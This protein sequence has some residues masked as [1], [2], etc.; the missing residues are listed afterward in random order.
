MQNENRRSLSSRHLTGSLSFLLP[1]FL[2]AIAFA[3]IGIHPIGNKSILLVD[4]KLQYVAFFSE[5]MRQLRFFELPLFS[6]FFGS[7]MNFY[8]TWAY[9][10]AS[11]VNLLL[12]LFPKAYI[13]D[14][15]FVVLLVKTGLC[16]TTFYLYARKILASE[17]WRALLFSTSYALC[18]FLVSYSDNMQWL[19][20]VIW[21]PIVIMG[22]EM[23]YRKGHCLY[24]SFAVA[25]LVISN[26]YISVLTG[27]FCFLYSTYVVLR[28]NKEDFPGRR[29]KF[30]LKIGWNSLLGVGMAAFV[31]LPI[32]FILRNQMNLIGQSAPPTLFTVNPFRTI[33]GLFVGRWDQFTEISFPKIYSGLLAVVIA[34]VYFLAGGI[35]RREKIVTVLFLA[36]VFVCFHV[37]VLNFIW[38]GLDYTGWFP[39]RY[40]FVFSFLILTA[41]VKAMNSPTTVF[42]K[43]RVF[44]TGYIIAAM[45]VCL[46]SFLFVYDS[47]GLPLLLIM[48]AAN[49]TL[50]FSYYYLLRKERRNLSVIL[51]LLCVELAMSTSFEIATLNSG[52]TYE[53][54]DTWTNSYRTVEATIEKN[55]LRGQPGRTAVAL[56]TITSND[57]LLFGLEG[58]DFYSSA[59]NTK[60]ADTL[61]RLGYQ[62]YISPGFEISDNGGSQ[63]LNSLMGVSS[64]IMETTELGNGGLPATV[65]PVR[66]L[67]RKDDLLE[68]TVIKNPLALSTAY[69]VSKDILS[70]SLSDQPK[71][72]LED[73]FALT[74]RLLSSML[75]NDK[76]TYEE[77]PYTLEYS[78]V[79]PVAVSTD[80]TRYEAQDLSEKSS[81]SINLLGKGEDMPLYLDMKYDVLGRQKNIANLS[82]TILYDQKE[83][84][85]KYPDE[86]VWAFVLSLGSFPEGQPVTVELN[87]TGQ[88]L[89]VWHLRLLSQDPQDVAE[90]LSPLYINQADMEWTSSNSMRIE[91]NA[92]ED[93]VLFVSIPYDAGW[94]AYVNGKPAEVLLIADAFM[95]IQ[96]E[97][98]ENVIEMSFFPDGLK[99]GIYISLACFAVA[100]FQ[101]IGSKKQKNS[102]I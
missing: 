28:E 9:Y 51:L 82:V 76:I 97:K 81:V 20:G 87:Y 34:P 38:H 90:A 86:T 73:P 61:Y 5:Y 79:Q 26:F 30:L 14:G 37:S 21:L 99:A 62:R 53:N 46:L 54:Y 32:F 64:T 72:L 6:R 100:L 18:G 57:P 31:L 68:L 83:Q 74:D 10:L 60:L 12:L 77:V 66:H 69:L 55:N 63:L 67:L 25:V 52:A 27:V 71:N 29:Q 92:E 7:G 80:C 94:R 39:F 33:G 43:N 75:N 11:P 96:L 19:D 101:I 65:F 56:E 44:F 58:I 102:F 1:V 47:M 88:D 48:A 49:C 42:S 84:Q 13:L 41:A 59:G 95:G 70:F 98:G 16:G 45:A 78:N 24:Y 2:M 8:G 3:M 35:K 4:G 85:I 15:M 36:F 93:G 89:Y 23:I 22:I 17:Q 91:E 40:S 50:L